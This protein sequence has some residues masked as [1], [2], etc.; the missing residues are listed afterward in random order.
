MILGKL[1]IGTPT[2]LLYN[3]NNGDTYLP[4]R[5]YGVLYTIFHIMYMPSCLVCNVTSNRTVLSPI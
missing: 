2:E 4:S 3:P 1:Q 5:I